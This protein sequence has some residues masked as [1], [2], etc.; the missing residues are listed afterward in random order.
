[1]RSSSPNPK[2]K[3]K[4]IGERIYFDFCKSEPG[5]ILIFFY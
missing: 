3:I 1:M 2:Y 5:I 4:I